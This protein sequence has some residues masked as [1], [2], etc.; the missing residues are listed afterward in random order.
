[1]NEDE[2]WTTKEKIGAAVVAVILL[3]V[4]GS[5]LGGEDES[6]AVPTT[7]AGPPPAASGV[8]DEEAEPKVVVKTKTKTVVKVPAA[9]SAAMDFAD[10]I[11]L[12]YGEFADSTGDMYGALSQALETGDVSILLDGLGKAQE[13]DFEGSK[14]NLRQYAAARDKCRAKVADAS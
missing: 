10:E 11:V 4:L 13:F 1:M 7:D 14:A 9:C 6:K 2:K 12:D 8:S 3:M 5:C